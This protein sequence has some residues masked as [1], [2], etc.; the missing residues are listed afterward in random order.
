MSST[1]DLLAYS[2]PPCDAYLAVGYLEPEC[3]APAPEP[4]NFVEPAAQALNKCKGHQ[5]LRYLG[6]RCGDV[7]ESCLCFWTLV[8]RQKVRMPA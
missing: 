5:T 6:I 1:G 3:P 2:I 7:L 4:D 8:S